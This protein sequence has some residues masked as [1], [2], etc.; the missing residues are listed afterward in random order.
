MI[1][2]SLYF[3]SG[4][5]PSLADMRDR[6]RKNTFAHHQFET[7]FETQKF[8][9]VFD[10]MRVLKVDQKYDPEKE[11]NTELVGMLAKGHERREEFKQ[12]KKDEEDIAKGIVKFLVDI[13]DETEETVGIA[14]ILTMVKK[15]NQS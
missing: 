1:P 5:Q 13:Y 4:A 12:K 11:Y 15:I 7:T 3:S 14:T 9:K 2:S 10:T 8:K 6:I